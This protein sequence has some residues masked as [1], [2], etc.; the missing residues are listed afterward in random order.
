MEVDQTINTV[1]Q[2]R[3][4]RCISLIHSEYIMQAGMLV[5][6]AVSSAAP[7]TAQYNHI[8]AVRGPLLCQCPAV[9]AELGSST[10]TKKE[11]TFFKKNTISH[12]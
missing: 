2:Q 10:A 8:P 3:G 4:D 12:C 7:R 6:K 11:T 1:R 5:P 9:A